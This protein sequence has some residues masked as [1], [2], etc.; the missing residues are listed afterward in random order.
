VDFPD[1]EK[2][3]EKAREPFL[4]VMRGLDPRIHL[5]AKDGLHRTWACPR[6]ALL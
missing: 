3:S 6:S 5:F 1:W 2:R 4:L